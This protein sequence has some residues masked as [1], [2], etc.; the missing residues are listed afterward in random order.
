MAEASFRIAGNV[1][2]RATAVAGIAAAGATGRFALLSPGD[3]AT[4]AGEWRDLAGRAAEDNVFFEPDFVL[5]AIEAIEGDTRIA[6]WRSA[7]GELAGLAPVAHARLGRIAP[8]I[9][10][11]SHEYGPLG[12]PLIDRK[13]VERSVAGLVGG[14]VGDRMSLIVPD[15]PTDGAVSA[16]IIRFAAGAGRPVAIV[17]GCQRAMLRRPASGDVD[18]R[19]A[20]PLRR[21]KE[22]ARQMRRLADLGEVA[23]ESASEPDRVRAR[24]EEFLALEASGWKG[25]GGT[26]LGSTS[27]IAEMARVIVADLAARRAV[28][29]DSIRLE[30]RPIAMLVSFLAKETAYSWKIAFDETY[31]R[32]SPGAQL[33]L[34]A[35]HTLLSNDGIRQID[36]CATAGHPMIDHLWRDRLAVGTLAMGPVG[37]GALFVAGLGA[38]RAEVR[39]R[40][41][42]R[43]LLRGSVKRSD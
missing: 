6:T 22:F 26:A 37:G 11:R 41:A 39:L 23:I 12:T 29:I 27:P 36:S 13:T 24:F 9:R 15:L 31:A 5:P 7:A 43:R 40:A 10:I 25:H 28:R 35:G 8:A 32:F 18:C 19:A 38:M 3:A 33:M 42:A 14:L 2:K 30:A 34:E 1:P 16:A 20:L 17:G 4:I 21:R